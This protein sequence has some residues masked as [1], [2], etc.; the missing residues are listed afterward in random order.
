MFN[1]FDF[2]FVFAFGFKSKT[3]KWKRFLFLVY[4]CLLKNCIFINELC[5]HL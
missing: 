2:C 4:V 5:Y 1:M 3:R